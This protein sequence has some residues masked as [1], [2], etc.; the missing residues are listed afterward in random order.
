MPFDPKSLKH[1]I[2]L[3]ENDLTQTEMGFR[4]TRLKTECYL[5]LVRGLSMTCA[6]VRIM[7]IAITLK[8]GNP[9]ADYFLTFMS[10]RMWR[11]CVYLQESEFV[12]H[13]T[14]F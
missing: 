14:V 4:E 6:L 2:P 9:G 8:K 13:C 5:K 1:D 7:G 11:L 10:V 12:C 3:P